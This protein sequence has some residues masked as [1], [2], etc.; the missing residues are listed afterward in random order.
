MCGSAALHMRADSS[1]AQP[2]DACGYI[3]ADAVVRF[4]DAALAEADGWLTAVLP[5][6]ASLAAVQ[7]REAALRREAAARVL[8]VAEVSTLVRHYSYLEANLQ[9][10]EE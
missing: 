7:R 2:T 9:A 3:A 6:Y 5:E 8:E 4:C 1:C 10:E